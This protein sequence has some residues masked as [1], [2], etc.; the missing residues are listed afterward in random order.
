VTEDSTAAR[1]DHDIV[2]VIDR[3]GSMAW[4]LSA[5][6][7]SYPGNLNGKS[8]IQNYFL[9]PHATLSRWAYLKNAVSLFITEVDSQSY[10]AKIGLVTYSSNFTFGTFSST[11]STTEQTLSTNYANINTR[12]TQLGQKPLI[13]DTNMEQGMTDG[14]TVLMD[15]TRNRMTAIKTM[16]LITDGIV[17]QGGNP[18]TLAQTL[19]NN[20]ITCH[21]ISFGAN[22]DKTLCA[23]I[24]SITG[25]RYYDAPTSTALQA[26]FADI[27]LSL[28]SILTN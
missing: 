15:T 19:K 18:R 16:I 14:Q 24:A 22:A 11:A 10:D 6:K 23:E 17:T 2:I 27:A 21:T 5:K 9:P 20:R 1:A 28:P 3:S 8:T 4:D 25:G 7:F 13:G 12:L 26:A